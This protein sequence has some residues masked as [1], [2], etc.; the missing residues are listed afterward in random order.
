[1]LE[2]SGGPFQASLLKSRGKSWVRWGDAQNT[3]YIVMGEQEQQESVILFCLSVQLR[4]KVETSN[5]PCIFKY[6]ML[7]GRFKEKSVRMLTAI[8]TEHESQAVSVLCTTRGSSNSCAL[9][10]VFCYQSSSSAVGQ[11]K[12]YRKIHLL[13][14]L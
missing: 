11:D 9:L 4:G 5:D 10:V 6:A 2:S 3:K 13:T 8:F 14:V 12:K 7:I 1:M